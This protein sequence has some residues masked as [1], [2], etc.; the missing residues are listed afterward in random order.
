MYIVYYVQY[1]LTVTV[2]IM[3]IHH[4]S[5]TAIVLRAW[6]MEMEVLLCNSM[7]ISGE[8]EHCGVS[9]NLMLIRHT[10]RSGSMVVNYL[11][12]NNK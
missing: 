10:N 5:H 8:P 11:A 9:H 6:A 12:C 3:K 1:Q 4:V 2:I 7:S